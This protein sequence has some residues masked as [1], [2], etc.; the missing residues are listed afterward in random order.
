MNSVSCVSATRTVRGARS[1]YWNPIC[2]CTIRS[3]QKVASKTGFREPPAK[4]AMVTGMRAAATSLV[5]LVSVRTLRCV[6]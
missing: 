1:I 5:I 3:A 2:E 6:E 4:G